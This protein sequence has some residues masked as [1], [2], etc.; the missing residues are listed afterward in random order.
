MGRPVGL[1]RPPP[2]STE[3]RKVFGKLELQEN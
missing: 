1:D 2:Q 3:K